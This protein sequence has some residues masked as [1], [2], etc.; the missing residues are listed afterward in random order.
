MMR[1]YWLCLLPAIYSVKYQKQPG[2]SSK[3]VSFMNT[4]LDMVKKQTH[5]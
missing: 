1:K 2:R 5:L 3:R 4:V